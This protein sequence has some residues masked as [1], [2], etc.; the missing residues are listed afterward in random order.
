MQKEM[1]GM[2]QNQLLYNFAARVVD[3]KF[4]SLKNAIKGGG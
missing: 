4:N 1:G 2:M 3:R